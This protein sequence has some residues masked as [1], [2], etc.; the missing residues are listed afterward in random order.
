MKRFPFGCGTPAEVLGIPPTRAMFKDFGVGSGVGIVLLMVLPVSA[1]VDIAGFC[2]GLKEAL[3]K[4]GTVD[5][6]TMK[7]G[8]GKFGAGTAQLEMDDARQE[9]LMVWRRKWPTN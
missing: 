7:R 8:D 9:D 2:A 3:E 6:M 1:G 4:F 5:L